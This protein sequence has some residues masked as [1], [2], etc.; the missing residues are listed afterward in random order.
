[1]PFAPPLQTLLTP[2]GSPGTSMRM[3]G[4][5]PRKPFQHLF[6]SW[7][8]IAPGAQWAACCMGLPGIR[9]AVWPCSC[10][11]S[12]S[13]R[14]RSQQGHLRAVPRCVNIWSGRAQ[15]QPEWTLGLGSQNRPFLLSSGCGSTGLFVGKLTSA[16]LQAKI[17]ML[18]LSTVVKALSC[19]LC[20]TRDWTIAIWVKI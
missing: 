3:S 1:M 9:D 11:P 8:T 18:S 15:A 6:L 7:P 16:N 10:Q 14:S 2:A 20:F 13:S 19:F 12:Q 17:Q 5:A 4:Q